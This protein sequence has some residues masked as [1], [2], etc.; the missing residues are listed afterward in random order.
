MESDGISVRLREFV[1][2]H[3]DISE[4]D[5]E[6]TDDVNL[7]DYGYVDSFSAV[8]IY[9]FVEKE[10]AISV[11]DAEFATIPLNTIREISTFLAQRRKEER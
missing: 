3:C 7:F 2:H 4:D 10:F 9:A 8:E 5:H 6:F 1:R 11:S